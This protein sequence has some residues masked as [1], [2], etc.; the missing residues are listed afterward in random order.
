MNR[1]D[2]A[3]SSGR[4][5]EW[6]VDS[7]SNNFKIEKTWTHRVW[8]EKFPLKCSVAGRTVSQSGVRASWAAVPARSH[9]PTED[10]IISRLVV[11]PSILL[12]SAPNPVFFF[13][14]FLP[15]QNRWS[16]DSDWC[17]VLHAATIYRCQLE[18][19]DVFFF[20]FFTHVP[21]GVRCKCV[22][23]CPDS[24]SPTGFRPGSLETDGD[25]EQ[26]PT[27]DSENTQGNLCSFSTYIILP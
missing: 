27:V 1:G 14:F 8:S 5:Y 9:T 6:L 21:C 20:F 16:S 11:P 17:C 3:C 4:P 2:G 18:W 12:W 19:V 10:G 26:E 22:K 23:V 25:T 24:S 7:D 15:W 13:F